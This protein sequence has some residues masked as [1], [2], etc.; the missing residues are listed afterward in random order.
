MSHRHKKANAGNTLATLLWR[1]QTVCQPTFIAL[2]VCSC[3]CVCVVC[4]TEWT[5]SGTCPRVRAPRVRRDECRLL[6]VISQPSPPSADDGGDGWR[7]AAFAGWSEAFALESD[8]KS[9]TIL[10]PCPVKRW[11][12]E[13]CTNANAVGALRTLARNRRRRT[14]EI[15]PRGPKQTCVSTAFF[16]VRESLCRCC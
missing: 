15:S 4:C 13:S 3:V 5:C 8:L 16:F 6:L 14:A 1:S 9:L 11:A 12:Y 7:W 10:L 2:V